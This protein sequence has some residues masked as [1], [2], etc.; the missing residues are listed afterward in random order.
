MMMLIAAIAIWLTLILFFVALCR[1]AASADGRD[2]SS[3]EGYPSAAAARAGVSAD[4]AGLVLLE[5][6]P[7]DLPAP[8]A[9]DLRARAR[10]ARGRAGQYAAGS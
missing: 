5:N 1:G 4:F 9:Q 7:G 3:T 6:R 2:T 8:S 10:G